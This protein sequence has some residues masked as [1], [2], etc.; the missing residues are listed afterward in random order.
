MCSPHYSQNPALCC[1]FSN[2]KPLS[3]CLD[4]LENGFMYFSLLLKPQI[5]LYSRQ[6]VHLTI[7]EYIG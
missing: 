3:S 2:F 5:V 4:T 6:L 7:S 1:G